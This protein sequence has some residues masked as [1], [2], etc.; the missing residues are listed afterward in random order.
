MS[1]IYTGYVYLWLDTKGKF[2]YV[3]GHH[4]KV[5]DSY[6]CS[7]KTMKRAYQ[8]RPD[9]F[10]LKILEYVNGNTKD[11][12]IAEQHW[13]NLIKDT[14]LMV[15]ENV[16]NGTCRYYN[17]KK[18]AV[19]GNGS[20]NKGNHNLGGHN[21]GVS[22]GKHS[23]ET[24]KIISEKKKLYWNSQSVKKVINHCLLCDKEHTNKQYCSRSCASKVKARN[25]GVG[26]NFGKNR[27]LVDSVSR[28]TSK[29]QVD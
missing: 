17:V 9:T 1:N 24:K 16:K 13:L 2:Y 8:K 26:K 23:S 4:G 25:S 28:T 15:S 7:S 19:G 29:T 3:G 5:E 18:N 11:L 20:A 10:K 12:R 6:V 22:W 14:E 27:M 21:K